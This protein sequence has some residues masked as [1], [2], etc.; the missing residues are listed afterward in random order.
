MFLTFED[1]PSTSPLIERVWRCYSIVGGTFYSM[2]E[3]NIEL[4]VTRLPGLTR[5]T[6]RGPVSKAA[7][8]DCPP[9]GRWLAIRF[10][11]GTYLPNLPT[12][13]LLDH[14]DID[15]PL[16]SDGRF[17]L[18]GSAWEIPSYGNAEAFVERLA[19][20]GVIAY[21][22]T[23][24]RAI[25]GDPEFIALRSVQRHFLRATGMAHARIRQIERARH[26][27]E[28]LREGSTILDVVDAAGYSDQAHLTR[29]LKQL[30]GQTPKKIARREAQ[31]SFSF[32]TAPLLYG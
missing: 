5:V 4:V 20:F 21:D 26:A 13:L 22:S 14:S 18:E 32:K 19:R 23:V 7:M 29:S 3:Y 25:M 1:R 12:A 30:I 24:G 9:N 10:R 16:T 15:L 31:L 8:V 17:W 11:L 6:L 2:A 28:M 27:V